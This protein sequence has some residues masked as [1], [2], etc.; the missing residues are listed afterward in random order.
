MFD[1]LKDLDL[2][3]AITIVGAI[4][5]VVIGFIKWFK[6][7][8]IQNKLILLE[9]QLSSV[10]EKVVD[11]KSDVERLNE[12]TDRTTELMIRYLKEDDN[13]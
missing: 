12:K 2:P 1:L 5:A 3:L 6:E 4:F 13:K 8:G 7:S 10:N 11:L 9:G